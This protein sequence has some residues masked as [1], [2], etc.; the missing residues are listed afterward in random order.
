[1]L[2][3]PVFFISREKKYLGFPPREN[4]KKPNFRDFFLEIHGT[5]SKKITGFR[6]MIDIVLIYVPSKNRLKINIFKGP[7]R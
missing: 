4:V 7:T 6:S 2:N 1:M 3:Y 5:P